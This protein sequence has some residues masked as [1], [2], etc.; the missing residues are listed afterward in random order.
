MEYKTI[1]LK[2]LKEMVDKAIAIK[3]EDTKVEFLDEDYIYHTFSRAIGTESEFVV[4]G[5]PENLY[6]EPLE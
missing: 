1:T 3:G 5:Q 2:D 6:V 4:F